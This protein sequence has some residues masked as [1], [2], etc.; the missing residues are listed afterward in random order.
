MQISRRLQAIGSRLADV[1]TDHGYVPIYLMQSK[2]IVF[3]VASDVR[4]GPLARA[5]QN[6]EEAGLSDYIEVRLSDGLAALKKGEA[7]TILIAGMGGPLMERILQ[8]RLE[9]ACAAA[10]LILQPQSEIPAFRRFLAKAGLCVT[11]SLSV[12]LLS[13]LPLKSLLILFFSFFLSPLFMISKANPG[14]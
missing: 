1:G 4:P 10:E 13:S 3:A 5:K 11:H 6:I 9:T 2:R 7:D 8:E 14:I 12:L